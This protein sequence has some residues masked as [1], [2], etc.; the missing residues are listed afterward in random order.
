MKIRPVGAELLHVGGQNDRHDEANNRF[1]F[2]I[3]RD[4]PKNCIYDFAQV[5]TMSN[6]QGGQ[7]TQACTFAVPKHRGRFCAR[8]ILSTPEDRNGS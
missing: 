5:T 1:F 7:H 8:P 4:A 2:V 6:S 3:L